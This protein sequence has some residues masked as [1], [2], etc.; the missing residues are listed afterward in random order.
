[1]GISRAY[2][3]HGVG[4]MYS[5][6]Q[7]VEGI[8]DDGRGLERRH[9]MMLY[10]GLV[11]VN[12]AIGF[13]PL[14]VSGVGDGATA[15]LGE[16]GVGAADGY[17]EQ[18]EGGAVGEGSANVEQDGSAEGHGRY[19]VE[20]STEH[21]NIVSY[22]VYE[23][24]ALRRIVLVNAHLRMEGEHAVDVHLAG[25]RSLA[26]SQLA[27]RGYRMMGGADERNAHVRDE[28]AA[29]GMGDADVEVRSKVVL[30]R[31]AVPYTTA[32]EGL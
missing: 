17:E 3:S 31:L 25:L 16:D 32:V 5:S 24:H 13:G 14:S 6:F 4:Y 20:L 9:I 22:G 28:E 8:T 15:G 30:K 26:R 1:L 19:V 29:D 10:Y 21:P 12:E 18:S 7:P 23:H 11:V 27:S 2:L